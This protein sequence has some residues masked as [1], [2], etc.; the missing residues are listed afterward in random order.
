[1]K[2]SI[3]VWYKLMVGKR[4]FVK[5]I[6]VP[7]IPAVGTLLRVANSYSFKV[8]EVE[9][10]LDAAEDIHDPRCNS[11]TATVNDF[12][13]ENDYEEI[14]SQLIKYGWKN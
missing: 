14:C 4:S 12:H 11:V 1:M 8:T 10:N 7:N 13:D 6:G 9:Q 3:N 5:I 2:T